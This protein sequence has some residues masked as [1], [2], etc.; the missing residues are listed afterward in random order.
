MRRALAAIVLV[1]GCSADEPD[2]SLFDPAAPGARGTIDLGAGV[3]GQGFSTLI[4]RMTP[5]GNEREMV[6]A[7]RAP[8]DWPTEFFIGGGLGS[9]VVNDWILDVWLGASADETQP[10]PAAPHASMPIET[11]CQPNGSCQVV[12]G[13]E[14]V[15]QYE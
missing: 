5:L 1:A 13:L 8:H 14:L 4:V 7:T 6:L 10:G 3:S 15:L 9:S 12:H 2:R 11:A